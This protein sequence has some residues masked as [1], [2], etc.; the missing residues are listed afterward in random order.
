MGFHNRRTLFA[1]NFEKEN[2]MMVV[3]CYKSNDKWVVKRAYREKE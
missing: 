2:T 1:F 3:Q